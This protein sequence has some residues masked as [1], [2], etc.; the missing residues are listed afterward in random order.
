MTRAEYLEFVEEG[1]AFP[2]TGVGSPDPGRILYDHDAVIA[3]LRAAHAE[4]CK[5][6]AQILE[7]DR[8]YTPSAEELMPKTPPVLRLVP[9]SEGG[10]AD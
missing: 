10:T 4:Y 1:L 3:S 9:D 7:I 6:V 8:E 2:A 5:K